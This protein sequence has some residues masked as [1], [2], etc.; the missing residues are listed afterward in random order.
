MDDE[1][2]EA[3]EAV[4][5]TAVSVEPNNCALEEALHLKMEFTTLRPVASASWRV[6]F[7]ADT[8]SARK[9]IELGGTPVEE[10]AAGA[11]T[12]AFSVSAVDVAHLKRHVLANVGLLQALLFSGERE[13]LQV[14]MVTQVTPVGDTLVRSVYNPLE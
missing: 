9:V 2:Q 11:N 7:V 13:L 10:Y 8:A 4:A 14:S 5:M 3:Q 12:M 1:A 6:R